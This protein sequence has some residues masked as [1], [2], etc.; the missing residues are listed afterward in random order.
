[1]LYK[2]L[3]GKYIINCVQ[4]IVKFIKLNKNKY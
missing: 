3:H 1:M 4:N 2:N